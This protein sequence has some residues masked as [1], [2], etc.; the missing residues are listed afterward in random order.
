MLAARYFHWRS[1]AF[2]GGFI[3]C[4]FSLALLA[5]LAV[6]FL[7]SDPFARYAGFDGDINRIPRHA[8]RPATTMDV[9][10]RAA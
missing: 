2:I 10:R 9:D 3:S 1:F 7:T 6:Q 5:S 8:H 4:I